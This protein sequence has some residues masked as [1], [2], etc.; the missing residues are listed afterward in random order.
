MSTAQKKV[1]SVYTGSAR[2]L[3][4]DVTDV[5]TPI[6]T[7]DFDITCKLLAVSFYDNNLNE[8]E[9]ERMNSES[10]PQEL[11]NDVFKPF[12]DQVDLTDSDQTERFGRV[13]NKVVENLKQTIRSRSR[14]LSLGSVSPAP[15]SKRGNSEGERSDE[16]P[17][18]LADNRPS[19]QK[20]KDNVPKSGLPQKKKQ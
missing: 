1:N 13:R 4:K 17:S 20:D 11:Q 5:S 12:R 18:K 10:A 6:I 9:V 3:L 7:E 14:R 19:P 16:K 8:E 2:K 15:A